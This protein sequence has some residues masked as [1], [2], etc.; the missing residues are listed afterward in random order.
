MCVIYSSPSHR[1]LEWQAV[2]LLISVYVSSGRR[3]KAVCFGQDSHMAN[4]RKARG[5][6]S[7]IFLYNLISVVKG[8][9]LRLSFFLLKK[10]YLSIHI[11]SVSNVPLNSCLQLYVVAVGEMLLFY[12]I[13]YFL[14]L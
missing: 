1:G 11:C 5:R 4:L 14:S 10:K 8:T 7:E 2:Q 9:L 3:V 13:L 6:N 12:F